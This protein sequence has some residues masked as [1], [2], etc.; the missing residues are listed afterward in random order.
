[1]TVHC[2]KCIFMS[3][4]KKVFTTEI[5]QQCPD[6]MREKKSTRVWQ[7]LLAS[8]QFKCSNVEKA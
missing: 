8:F 7:F 5:A 2:I 1:M 3:W 4:E 6:S